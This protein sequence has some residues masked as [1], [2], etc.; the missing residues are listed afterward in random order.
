MG[1]ERPL[2]HHGPSQR[3]L[4]TRLVLALPL[5]VLSCLG[6]GAAGS[7]WRAREAERRLLCELVI[8]H[9]EATAAGEGAPRSAEEAPDTVA[10]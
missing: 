9:G 10:A 6:L 5:F 3:R 8:A 4:I 1:S 2:L 7:L